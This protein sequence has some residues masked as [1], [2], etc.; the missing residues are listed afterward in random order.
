MSRHTWIIGAGGIGLNLA[1]SCYEL[2]ETVMLIS[3]RVLDA[4]PFLTATLDYKTP[5]A[6]LDFV[7]HHKL[8]DTLIIT[9]GLLHDASN[10]PEK[11]I[12][13]LKTTWL[14]K[15]IAANVYPTLCWLQALSFVLN[16]N[17]TLKVMCFSAKVGSITDNKLGGWYSYRMSKAMLNMLVKT[18]ALEWRVNFPK[19]SLIAYHP[20]TVDTAL[21]QPFSQH[22]K[23]RVFSPSEAARYCIEVRDTLRPAQSGQLLDWQNQ[24]LSF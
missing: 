18:T 11:S 12:R 10:R 19:T 8:P 24:V 6:V 20:G 9:S 1:Q 22:V 4:K 5:L 17:T 13:Q 21:S 15:N 14:E 2:G 23:H 16:A 7:K 3:R